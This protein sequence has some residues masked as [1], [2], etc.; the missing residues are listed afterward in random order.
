M[1]SGDSFRKVGDEDALRV[2]PDGLAV[3]GARIVEFLLRVPGDATVAL[4][5]SCC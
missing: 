1:S 5:G 2:E 4:R 3:I